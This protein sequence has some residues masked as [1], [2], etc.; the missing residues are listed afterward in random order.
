MRIQ[1]LISTLAAGSSSTVF[2]APGAGIRWKM[3]YGHISPIGTVVTASMSFYEHSSAATSA[4]TLLF[5]FV[6][7]TQ[8]YPIEMN[9][10]DA[11]GWVATSAD[12]GLAINTVGGAIRGLFIG[13]TW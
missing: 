8:L 4:T 10:K 5:G 3:T 2:D 11:G 12:T 6:A 1:R 9:L 13:E 7:A